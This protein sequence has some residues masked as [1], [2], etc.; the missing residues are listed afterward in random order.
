LVT[1][2]AGP[3]PRRTVDP[4]APNSADPS[5]TR[6]PPLVIAHRGASETWP[7]NTIPAFMAGIDQGADM[8]E[9]DVHMSAD[10]ELVIMHDTTVA[11][12]LYPNRTDR[13]I[14]GMTA[15]QIGTLDA[16]GWK[17]EEFAGIRVPRLAEVLA[18]VHDTRTGLLLEVKHPELYPAIAEAIVTA[19]EAVP[20]YLQ[21]ALAA[22]M[23]V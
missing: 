3:A 13:S 17:G 10:G 19:L 1:P 20:N 7:E 6:V 15:A 16:G 12:T 9:T 18:L 4:A 14:A 8:I 22:G 21:R 5:R 23:L 11:R 2:T